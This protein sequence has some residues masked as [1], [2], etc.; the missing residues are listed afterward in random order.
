ME[1]WEILSPDSSFG[2]YRGYITIQINPGSPTP[3][4][5]LP[6]LGAQ[7]VPLSQHKWWS[8]QTVYTFEGGPYSRKDLVLSAANKDGGAHVDPELDKYYE[9][10]EKGLASMGLDGRNLVY[11]NGAPYDQ[12]QVQYCQN[13]HVAM[14]RQFW[15]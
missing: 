9:H 8:E 10:L 6:K 13:T 7:F 1:D 14:I 12:S 4:R 11:P 15:T 2:D 3:V 5:A